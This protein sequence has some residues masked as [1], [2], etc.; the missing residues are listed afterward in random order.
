MSLH[1]DIKYENLLCQ[2]AKSSRVLLEPFQSVTEL[3]IIL[4]CECASNVLP[5]SW[6][7]FS[8]IL[9]TLRQAGT[10]LKKTN[11]PTSLA[12]FIRQDTRQE[13]PS[14]GLKGYI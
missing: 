4:C 8:Y 3:E 1:K 13:T 6:A 5:P 9:Q 14:S 10:I 7:S 12:W 11:T 2:G